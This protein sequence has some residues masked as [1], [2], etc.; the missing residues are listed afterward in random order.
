MYIGLSLLIVALTAQQIG[1]FQVEIDLRHV[2][3][4]FLISIGSIF[5]MHSMSTQ[6]IYLEHIFWLVFVICMGVM[7]VPIIE[8]S[9][10]QIHQ[11][12][13]IVM[14]IMVI[15]SLIA[16]Y[17]TNNTFSPLLKYLI[18]ILFVLVIVELCHIFFYP[19]SYH[20]WGQF[21]DLVVIFV[22]CFIVLADTQNLWQKAMQCGHSA[23]IDYPSESTKIF[24]DILNLFA[25]VSSSRSK[26]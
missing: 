19:E 16:F 7:M 24:L 9:M 15:L 23:C 22:F 2:I 3:I 6:S 14:G 10:P 18:V 25:R 20:T 17:D 4:S 26:R 5:M 12:I 11:N 21:Y 13:L 8:L 1:K